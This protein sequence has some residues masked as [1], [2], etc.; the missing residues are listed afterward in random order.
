MVLSKV[1][2]IQCFTLCAMPIDP[3]FR[4]LIVPEELID[5]EELIYPDVLPDPDAY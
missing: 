5:P 4:M 3:D 1:I 2:S